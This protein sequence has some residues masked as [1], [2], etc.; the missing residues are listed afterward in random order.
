MECAI[1]ILFFLVNVKSYAFQMLTSAR[2]LRIAAVECANLILFFLVNV[3]SYAFQML[4]SARG[5]R[6]AAVEE[7]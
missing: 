4:T 2:G 1:L 3:K 7:R 5:L 6:I